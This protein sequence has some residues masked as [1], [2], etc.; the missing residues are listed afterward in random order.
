MNEWM[1]EFMDEFL[2]KL[3]SFLTREMELTKE[4]VFKCNIWQ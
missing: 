1:D 2:H 3:N 4:S